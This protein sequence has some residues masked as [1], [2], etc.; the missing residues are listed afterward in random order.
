VR[1]LVVPLH[2]TYAFNDVVGIRPADDGPR[3]QSTTMHNDIGRRSRHSTRSKVSMTN[4]DTP[5]EYN[6]KPIPEKRQ[7]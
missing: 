3:G 7:G 6:V 5:I 4:S 1:V 2:K